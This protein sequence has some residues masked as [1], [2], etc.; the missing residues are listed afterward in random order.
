MSIACHELFK[1]IEFLFYFVIEK[2][3]ETN[4]EGEVAEETEDGKMAA[5]TVLLHGSLKVEGMVA[6]TQVA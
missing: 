1:H 3:S 5:F 4:E 2:V 6:L